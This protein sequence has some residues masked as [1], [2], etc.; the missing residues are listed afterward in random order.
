LKRSEVWVDLRPILEVYVSIPENGGWR[1][2]G[3]TYGPSIEGFRQIISKVLSENLEHYKDLILRSIEKFF[4]QLFDDVVKSCGYIVGFSNFTE[5]SYLLVTLNY[6]VADILCLHISKS[7]YRGEV[8]V[9]VRLA[10][11]PVGSVKIPVDVMVGNVDRIVA[12]EA[13]T[14]TRERNVDLD[15]IIEFKHRL[16]KLKKD[17]K[18]PVDGYLVHVYHDIKRGVAFIDIYKIYSS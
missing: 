7:R 15:I 9:H 16:E 12:I 11:T 6:S 10:D 18:I 17:L 8:Q 1:V 2:F 13:K 14:S 4:T 3:L 5:S